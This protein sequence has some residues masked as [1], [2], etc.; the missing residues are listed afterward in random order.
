MNILGFAGLNHDPSIALLVDGKICM[1]IESEK[2]TRHKHE[3]SFFPEEAIRYVLASA[4][5]TVR[6]VDVITTNWNAGPLSNGLYLKHAL[7]F[8]ARRSHPWF[9]LPVL[10]SICGTHHPAAFLRLQEY[11]LPKIYKVRHHLAHLGSCYT[12]SPF[13]D[14]AVAIIDG[15]GELECTSLYHCTGRRVNKLGSMDLPLDSIGHI[16]TMATVHLGYRMLGDEYKVMGLT[17]YGSR[18]R[19]YD[20]FFNDLIRLLPEGGYR[21]DHALA[22]NYMVNGY[23]FPES[24]LPRICAP[25]RMGEPMTD[26]HKDF[27]HCLQARVEE[28]ILHVLR[29]LRKA[30]NSRHL[31]LAG[32]VALNC[33]ANGKIREH[34][35]FDDV[36]IQPAAH[37]AGTSLGAAAYYAY[38][39][40]KQG[41]PESFTSPYLGPGFDGSVVERE[42][43]RCR[44]PYERVEN[45]PKAAATL[46]AAGKVIGWMQGRAEFGPRALG[47]RS[48]LADPRT[49]EMKDRVNRLVKERETYRPFAPALLAEVMERY[50]T[51]IHD[52]PY[53]LLAGKVRPERRAEIPAVTHVDGTARPQS[54]REDW[55]P[56]FYHLIKE[57]SALTDVPVV[58]N[59]SFNVAGEPIVITPTDAVRCFYGSGLD[60]LVIGDYLLQKTR[61]T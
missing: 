52:S 40:A 21:V 7:K 8:V 59:T 27:A 61:I 5:M 13:E 28:T 55:N 54:V 46:L 19:R 53:M 4:G 18:N 36:F 45:A 31:C 23:K 16:Y 57:F 30:T 6:D 25:R 24:T 49:P 10:M 12:L 37:D 2:V 9:L 35:D 43:Q 22:G 42:L 47:N 33:V 39:V 26:E 20:A 3:V 17:G 58:L 44:L 29:H 56:R 60:A 38:H 50:F 51:V 15:S 48:I 14:A 1:A 32:G 11:R 41:R 34:I